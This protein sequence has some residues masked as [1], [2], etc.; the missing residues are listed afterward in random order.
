MPTLQSARHWYSATDPV[1]GFDHIERVYRL[2]QYIAACEGANLE[3]VCA[4]ALL[5]DANP[6]WVTEAVRLNS[7]DEELQRQQHHH[8]SA[9]FA[10]RMLEKEGWQEEHIS[11]VQDCILSHRFRDES[12]QPETLEAR[13]LYDADKLD[14]IGAVGIARALAYAWQAGQPIYA[15][16]SDKFQNTGQLEPGEP[17]SAYHEYLF[18][19][20]KLK[21]TL[22]TPAGQ[23]L[24]EERHALLQAF[25]ENL[26]LEMESTTEQ[27]P[28][29]ERDRRP[30]L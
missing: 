15:T 23:R 29:P 19:L 9:E 18:K 28:Q 17:H 2:A 8:S 22:F 30:G 24:A 27:Y 25:F 7:E 13:V 3:I 10:A 20:R 11:A 6:A 21:A 16:V 12:Q 5:H 26:A 14:A 1:H 4:A